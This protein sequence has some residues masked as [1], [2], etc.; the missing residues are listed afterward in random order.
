MVDLVEDTLLVN[1]PADEKT[2]F[3]SITFLVVNLIDDLIS[4]LLFFLIFSISIE[5]S[6]PVVFLL[7]VVFNLK[8]S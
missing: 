2:L 8:L 4:E 1:N 5:V 3:L 7:S 6:P